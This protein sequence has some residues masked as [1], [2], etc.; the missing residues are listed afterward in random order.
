MIAAGLT[1]NRTHPEVDLIG[2]GASQI[3]LK[4]GKLEFGLPLPEYEYQDV[5][6]GRNGEWQLPKGTMRERVMKDYRDAGY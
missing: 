3:A 1:V 6:R 5:D 4:C 2:P